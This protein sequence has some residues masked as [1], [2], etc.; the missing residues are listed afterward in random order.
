MFER[1]DQIGAEVIRLSPLLL[2]FVASHF[3]LR[4]LLLLEHDYLKE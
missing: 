2:L 3:P 1:S 4:F